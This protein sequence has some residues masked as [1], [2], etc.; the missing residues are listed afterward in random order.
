MR[1]DWRRRVQKRV[2]G[3]RGPE[4]IVTFAKVLKGGHRLYVGGEWD[5]IGEL[6]FNFLVSRGLRPEH[7]FLDIACGSLRGGVHFIRYLAPGNYQGIDK[8]KILIRRGLAKELPRQ[9]REEKRPEFV[10]SDSFEFDRFS[11]PANFS[12]AQSLF[13]HLVSSE[14]E[15]CLASLRAHVAPGHELYATFLLGSSEPNPPRPHPHLRFHFS[16]E[17]FAAFGERNGWRSNYVGEWG[18]P[19]GQVMMQFVA[20]QMQ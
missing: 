16:R 10:V 3:D 18:H 1:G 2:F 8:E 14:V 9:V 15:H 6:Q 20:D 12:L 11:K 13:T 5:E 4:G 7:V 19:R 17:E